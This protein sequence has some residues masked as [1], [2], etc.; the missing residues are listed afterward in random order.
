MHLGSVYN[1]RDLYKASTQAD[2]MLDLKVCFPEPWAWNKMKYQASAISFLM[3]LQ[4]TK[5]T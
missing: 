5:E 3:E 1:K 2:P 4:D